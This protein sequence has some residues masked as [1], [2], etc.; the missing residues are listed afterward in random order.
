MSTNSALRRALSCAA[1]ILGGA[2][3]AQ[4]QVTITNADMFNQ[5]GQYY[6]AYANDPNSTNTVDVSGLLGTSNSVAQFWDFTTGPQD[7][8][9]RYDYLAATN[10]PYGADFVAAGAQMAQQ[11][12]SEG[13]TNALQWLYFKVDPVSGQLDHGFYDPSF[14]PA[15]PE[16]LFTPPLQDWPASIHYGDT[17][18]GTTIFDSMYPFSFGG[19]STNYPDQVTYT[20]TGTVD[21][22]GYVTLPAIGLLACLRVHEVVEYDIAINIDG[23]G[24]TPA[25]TAYVLNY[26][27]LAPGHGIVVQIVSQQYSSLPLR[28]DLG[29]QAATFERM[30]AAYHPVTTTTPT[31][32]AISGFK[33]TLGG[34]GAFLYWKV[35]TGVSSYTVEYT[36]N[37]AGTITWQPLGSVTPPSNFMMDPTAATPGAPVRYYRVVGTLGPK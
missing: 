36:T 18:S 21:A 10:T 16:S 9:N 4:A 32:N 34:T 6:L 3:V 33:M 29:G 22:F 24:Y 19:L 30:F 5:V 14:S 27:W 31:T 11:L 15:Q 1:A 26:Y 17:W 23:S 37:L 2:A 25:G 35:L 20:S 12:T 28:E 7:V 13:T 8:T